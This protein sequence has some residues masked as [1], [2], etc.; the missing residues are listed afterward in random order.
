MVV[1]LAVAFDCRAR[2]GVR[3]SGWLD[4]RWLAPRATPASGTASELLADPGRDVDPSEPWSVPHGTVRAPPSHPTPGRSAAAAAGAGAA[5]GSKGAPLLPRGYVA[6]GDATEA[7]RYVIWDARW[8]H[9]DGGV[10]HS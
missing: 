5:S 3:G 7:G 4:P 9:Q 2:R 6:P 10:S 8:N 1:A